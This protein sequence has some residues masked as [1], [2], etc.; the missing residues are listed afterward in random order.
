MWY[1]HDIN[2][3]QRFIKLILLYNR[4]DFDLNFFNTNLLHFTVVIH[5]D[6]SLPNFKRSSEKKYIFIIS[7]IIHPNDNHFNTI[8]CQ[9]LEKQIQ[10]KIDKAKH[11]Y[12]KTQERNT[13]I[14]QQTSKRNEWNRTLIIYYTHEQRL[15]HN[16]KDFHQLWDNIFKKTAAGKI[17][18]L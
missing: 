2:I 18:R 4:Y 7:I 10:S 1:T 8:R 16:K 3:E 13:K 11:Y 5:R 12:K 17:K 6:I 14:H 9:L 15:A